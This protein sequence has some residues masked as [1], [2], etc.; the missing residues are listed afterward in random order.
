M[1]NQLTSTFVA[2][3]MPDRLTAAGSGVMLTHERVLTTAETVARALGV[4]ADSAQAPTGEVLLEFT[5]IAPKRPV[6]AKVIQ[7]QPASGGPPG[8][9]AV[10]ENVALLELQE[11]MPEPLPSLTVAPSGDDYEVMA[12][13]MADGTLVPFLGA[14]VNLCGRPQNEP[15]KR[16]K[17]LPSGQE[18]AADLANKFR[19]PWPDTRD[20]VRVSQ[21]AALIRGLGPLNDHLRDVFNADYPP[22]ALHQFF[23]RLPSEM[24]KRNRPSSLLVVTT[25]YDDVLERAFREAHEPYD[26]ITYVTRGGQDKR[27]KFLHWTPE[28]EVHLVEVPNEYRLPVDEDGNLQRSV[29]LKVHGAVDRLTRKPAKPRDSFVITED[30]YID[31][32]TLSD[33]SNLVPITLA[34]KLSTSSFLFLGYSLR[35]WNPRVIL[36]RI[37]MEQ[38]QNENYISW[39]I[40]LDP[41]EL[42]RKL[43]D[44]RGVKIFNARLEDFIAEMGTRVRALPVRPEDEA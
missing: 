37:W 27:G 19:Y 10:I 9:S 39:A 12:D 43:W 16:G 3:L 22:T 2:V 24:R 21:Y 36:Y 44:E 7:W 38:Q 8:A 34:A 31:Y 4:S 30:Q 35:D 28:G 15:W 40:Q 1:S 32:L 14:G 23:A 41:E 17:F 33:I 26:L 25:N 20:L 13:A 29:I 6:R 11:P 42:E 5:F 18:L